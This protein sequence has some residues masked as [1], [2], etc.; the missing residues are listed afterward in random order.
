MYKTVHLL[1]AT[2]NEWHIENSKNH[3]RW[4]HSPSHCLTVN[5]LL[6]NIY[7]Y[8][9]YIKYNLNK[10]NVYKIL[11]RIYNVLYIYICCFIAITKFLCWWSIINQLLSTAMKTVNFRYF[12]VTIFI[13]GGHVTSSVTWPSVSAWALSYVLLFLFLL[14]LISSVSP[15][16]LV[17]SI[18]HL[19]NLL[20]LLY[21]KTYLK[22]WRS[23]KLP[24]YLQPVSHL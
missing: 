12:G 21:S 19:K 3:K 15:L 1:T 8:Y 2:C 6:N 13:F 14:S 11:Y 17:I 4:Y 9:I 24:P 5:V 16:A 18:L 20:Y 10:Y 23:V 7:I 22:H